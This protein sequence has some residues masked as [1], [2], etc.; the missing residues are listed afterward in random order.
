MHLTSTH[1]TKFALVSPGCVI[2]TAPMKDIF[3]CIIIHDIVPRD[4]IWQT[5]LGS[6]DV[7]RI[8]IDMRG[9]LH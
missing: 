6:E 7:E 1:D 3:G 8:K 2:D 5:S 9:T 4:E